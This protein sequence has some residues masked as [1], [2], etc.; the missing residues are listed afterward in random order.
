MTR[1]R[2]HPLEDGHPPAWASGWGQDRF[3]V[4]VEFALGE[5]EQRMRWIPPGTFQMG[6]P[7]SEAG[8]DD[9]ETLH[10][11]TLTQGFWLADTPC[12]QALWEGVMGKNPSRFKTPE[13]PV[14]KVSWEDARRFLAKLGDLV[15]GLA[16]RLPTEAEWEYACRAGTATAT[17]LGDLEILGLNDAPVLDDIAW[18]G[19]NSGHHGFDLKEAADS[20]DWPEKQYPH[21][22]AGTRKVKTRKA[23]PW[24]LYDM[25]GNVWEWCEDVYGPYDV[26][27]PNDPVR[28]TEGSNRVFRGGSWVSHARYVRAAYR[29]RDSP[30]ARWSD[31][32]FRLARGQV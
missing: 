32:G 25:L 17:Y 30:S 1:Y 19:G 13:R 22:Q 11:V 21:K 15:P 6:S 20:S 4:F 24:G 14:E 16:P 23:N 26:D 28:R 18:Y 31:L 9:D 2:P 3:G 29:Y 5:V 12:T 27:V 7:E 8:R 10:K